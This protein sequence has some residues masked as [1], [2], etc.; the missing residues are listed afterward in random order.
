MLLSGKHYKFI[1]NKTTF[2]LNF[3]EEINGFA[4][5]N[6]FYV[7]N[8]KFYITPITSP[9]CYIKNHDFIEVNFEEYMNYV[10]D[11]FPYK[12]NFL[13]KNK[14]KFLINGIS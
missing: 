8:E 13:R 2:F 10:P 7:K 9:L 1:N 11:D 3:K 4:I 12:I 14:I 5:T 6:G